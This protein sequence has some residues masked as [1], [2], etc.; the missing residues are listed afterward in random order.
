VINHKKSFPVKGKKKGEGILFIR[1]LPEE[2]HRL[3][4]AWCVRRGWTMTAAIRHFIRE[5]VRGSEQTHNPGK[6]KRNDV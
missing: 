5:C 2:D 1:N 3:F 6:G 4:K